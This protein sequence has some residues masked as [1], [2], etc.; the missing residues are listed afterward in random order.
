V[1]KE[2]DRVLRERG[3]E[4]IGACNKKEEERNDQNRI[5]SRNRHLYLKT[6]NEK[7]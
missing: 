3:N 7:E 5:N 2:E 6:N 1:R 4:R